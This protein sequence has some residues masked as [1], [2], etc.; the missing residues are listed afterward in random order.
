M[1]NVKCPK[2]GNVMKLSARAGASPA[3]TGQGK[4]KAKPKKPA[5]L[6]TWKLVS[7]I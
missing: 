1:A 7:G 4:T 5:P 6:S 3:S 2:C